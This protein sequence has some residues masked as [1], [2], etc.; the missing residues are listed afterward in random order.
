MGMFD[1]PEYLTGD[2]G[3]AKKGDIFWLH[4]AQQAGVV[5]VNG[6]QL[7]QVKLRVSHDRDGEQQEVFSGG[8]GIVNQVR[9]LDNE[10]R[11]S[12]PIQVRLATVDT[13]RGNPAY[14]LER[15]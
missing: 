2:E 12:M 6:K 8:L 14:T 3:F 10:D 9:R 5:T 15:V 13:G 11:R 1:K 7:E 4:D